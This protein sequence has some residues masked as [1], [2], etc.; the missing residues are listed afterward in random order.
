[1]ATG[2]H[3]HEGRNGGVEARFVAQAHRCV[4]LLRVR[5]ASVCMHAA[6]LPGRT[7]P[8]RVCTE[9][10]CTAVCTQHVRRRES[11]S[12]GGTAHTGCVQSNKPD[13]WSR[14]WRAVCVDRQSLSRM[15][16]RAA[17]A[18]P[19]SVNAATDL[20]PS[21]LHA[22]T[23]RHAI[24]ARLAMSTTGGAPAVGAM[25]PREFR[26]VD[27]PRRRAASRR[28]TRPRRRDAARQHLRP[29]RSR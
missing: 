12:N 2:A 22:R 27:R 24:S 7:A 8:E 25:A 23:T 26:G 28:G 16:G 20:T 1:M 29:L 9:G 21:F 3:A 15:R 13:H 11:R 18:A 19:G 4:R 14:L 17:G 10:A 5:R 6:G